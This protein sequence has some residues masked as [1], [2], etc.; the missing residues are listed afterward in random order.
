MASTDSLVT[1]L[2]R[3]RT[4]RLDEPVAR[5]ATRDLVRVA[6]LVPA[7]ATAILAVLVTLTKLLAGGAF[8]GIVGQSAAAWLVLNQVSLT[9]GGVTLGVLPL[10][11][12]VAVIVAVA[13]VTGRAARQVETLPEVG[14]IAGAALAGPLLWTALALAVVADGSAVSSIGQAAPLPAFGHT[15][16]VQGIGVGIGVGRRC[17]ESL[18][19][20]YEVPVTDRVGARA[21]MIAFLGLLAGGAVL[22]VA[23][24]AFGTG[25]VAG[26]IEAGDSFDGYLGLTGL[27]ILYLPN[28]VIGAAGL[29]VGATVQAGTASLDA[30]GGVAGQ[31][32][33]LPILGALP[34]HGLGAAGPAVFAIP[35]A[36][37]ALVSWYCRSI[38]TVRHLRAVVLAAAVCAALT[39][40]A[41]AMASG[42]AGELGRVGVSAPLAAVYAFGWIAGVGALGAGVYRLLPASRAQRAGPAGFDL[43]ALLESDDF[44]GLEIV[45]DPDAEVPETVESL[46]S[47]DLDETE[48]TAELQVGAPDAPSLAPGN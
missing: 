39:V 6:L 42:G 14:S 19:S 46:D 23:G 33:P 40:V 11:P 21:G 4:A 43:D 44:A 30:F 15:L 41:A 27:S 48:V 17:T 29:A 32:P 26:L 13:A 10:L 35:I 16:L 45:D 47:A 3:G 31:V 36:V 2:R 12:T 7:A 38:D 37:G 9:V 34:A 18:M 25:R 20:V 5:A 1:R 28:A 8:G 24:L 22:V